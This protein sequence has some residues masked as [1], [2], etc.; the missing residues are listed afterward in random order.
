MQ[1]AVCILGNK[2]SAI[3][4]NTANG[5]GDPHRV[6][7]KELVVFGGAQVT[8]HTQLHNELVDQFL[9][10]FLSQKTV[11]NISFE[12]N[13]K[14]R[15]NAAERHCCT[16]LLFVCGKV[17]KIDPLN[18]LVCIGSRAGNITA[19][20]CC[21]LFELAQKADLLEELF[22]LTNGL[23]VHTLFA[24]LFFIFGLFFNQKI[25]AVKCYS[26][27]VADDTATAV[28]IRQTG[29]NAG[30]THSAHGIGINMENTV[31]MRG[32]ITERGFDFFGKL[33]AVCLASTACHTNATKGVDTAHKGGGSL[34]TYNEFILA[35]K[36]TRR[37]RNKRG[38][39]LG[40]NINNTALFALFLQFFFQ[41]RHQ[42]TCALG[43]SCQK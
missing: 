37:I 13:I 36:I 4:A 33:S 16:V 12:V 19:V 10:A 43:G 17:C 41:F 30:F 28:S 8:D 6:S 38:N 29:Q 3:L 11:L 40:V 15:A 31:V 34:Q 18:S 39:C 24:E 20:K 23:L 21:H 9:C 1:E 2:R 25:N 14:E 22:G 42:A 27:V 5:F 35:V 26:A 32:A 7:A